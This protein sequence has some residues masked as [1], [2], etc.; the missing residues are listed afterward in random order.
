[1]KTLFVLL[2]GLYALDEL[3]NGN[4][5]VT[6][7]HY[8]HKVKTFED[9][10]ESEREERLKYYYKYMVVRDPFERLV[11]VYRNKIGRRNMKHETFLKLQRDIIEEF[12][13]TSSS[14]EIDG[15]IPSFSEFVQY[16][17]A[18]R[19]LLDDHFQ[20]MFDLCQPCL[21]K[22]NLYVNFHTLSND[23]NM[24]LPALRLPRQFYFNDI[25]I[26]PS[27]MPKN[28]SNDVL[29][30]YSQLSD[31]LKVKVMNKLTVDSEMYH[32]LYPNKK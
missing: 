16:F 25:K 10:S 14:S 32:H 22:Y 11:S 6:H 9:L 7:K 1:M 4:V 30:Y 3:S 23:M 13:I 20:A 21:I 5:H 29:E 27:L 31:D 24:L 8:L 18:H 12:R 26:G 15:K 17:I 19:N 28:Q 2:Q